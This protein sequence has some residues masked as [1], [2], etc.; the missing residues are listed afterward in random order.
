MTR[1]AYR[2]I[3]QAILRPHVRENQCGIE[4]TSVFSRMGGDPLEAETL[5]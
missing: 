5:H 2:I 4:H 1:S 3:V